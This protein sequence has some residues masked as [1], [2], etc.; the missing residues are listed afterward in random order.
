MNNFE[1][2]A[3]A[4]DLSDVQDSAASEDLLTVEVPSEIRAGMI[5]PSV[6]TCGCHLAE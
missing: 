3:V 2:D 1:I 6:C 4:R 5:T